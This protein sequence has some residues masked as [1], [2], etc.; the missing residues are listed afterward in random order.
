[1]KLIL[2][3]ASSFLLALLLLPM[4]VASEGSGSDKPPGDSPAGHYL[5]NWRW[6]GYYDMLDTKVV[7]PGKELVIKNTSDKPLEAV[8]TG[9]SSCESVPIPLDPDKVATF[10]LLEDVF[11]DTYDHGP[12]MVTVD[13]H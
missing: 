3:F 1:M 10:K 6:R 5:A 7:G 13:V 9:I 8:V 4:A 11:L 2:L 12:D